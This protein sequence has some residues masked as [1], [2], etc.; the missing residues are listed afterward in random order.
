M[1]CATNLWETLKSTSSED[2]LT[3]EQLCVNI[4]ALFANVEPNRKLFCFT[5]YPVTENIRG[6]DEFIWHNNKLHEVHRVTTTAPVKEVPLKL[7]G[8]LSS[9]ANPIT[10]KIVLLAP[11]LSSSSE[12]FCIEI[13]S[14]TGQKESIQVTP[15]T[16]FSS[17]KSVAGV[18]P[19]TPILIKGNFISERNDNHMLDFYD[20]KEGCKAYLA[21]QIRTKLFR[22][23]SRN[24]NFCSLIPPAEESSDSV[25]CRQIRLNYLDANSTRTELLVVHAHPQCTYETL[26]QL[27]KMETDETYFENLPMESLMA[28]TAQWSNF[29]SRNALSRLV[30]CL[31]ACKQPVQFSVPDEILTS[32]LLKENEFR[33]SAETQKKFAE[34]EIS[35]DIDWLFVVDDKQK[36]IAEEFAPKAG[37]SP[38]E[39]LHCMRFQKCKRFTPLWRKF[40]RANRGQLETKF[41]PLDCYL[42]DTKLDSYTTLHSVLA[43]IKPGHPKLTLLISGSIS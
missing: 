24:T 25:L 10:N 2:I 21:P 20:V 30:E 22:V 1:S 13:V 9:L 43:P 16:T 40:N 42:L 8:S 38:S 18:P 37:C 19:S 39:F 34:A 7:R 6:S 12:K 26:V 3:V 15:F 29:L 4:E 17:L 11:N 14:V 28:I 33:L 35:H 32:A 5:L 36:E 23:P 41:K 27:L 31:S